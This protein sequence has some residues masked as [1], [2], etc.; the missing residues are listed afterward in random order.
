MKALLPLRPVAHLLLLPLAAGLLLG[1]QFSAQVVTQ[2]PLVVVDHDNSALSRSLIRMIGTNQAF[3][4]NFRSDRDD[5]VDQRLF[6]GEAAA[7]LIVPRNFGADLRE[8]KN[9][10]ILAVYDGSQMS[11]SGAVKSRLNEVL[12]AVRAQF[13]VQY[14]EGKLGQT[15]TSALGTAV[16]MVVVTRL[17]GNPAKS[18]PV[19]ML[20][21]ALFCLVLV[22]Q[23]MLAI[24]LVDGAVTRRRLAFRAALAVVPGTLALLL[25]V[26][27]QSGIFGV[28]FQGTIPAAL[29]LMVLFAASIT[30]LGV[31]LRLALGSR[32]SAIG[33]AGFLSAMMLFAGYTFPLFAMPPLFQGFAWFLPFTHFG[34]PM[35]DLVLLG[36]TLTQVAP[37]LGWL[38]GSVAVFTVGGWALVR[39]GP[40]VRP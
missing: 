7:G 26:V 30:G 27:V 29:S 23:A 25:V 18:T 38:A 16:P 32:R 21:G 22:A 19:F 12:G 10:R 33:V 28:P 24:D 34:L 17:L 37:D 1:Y 6:R 39:W 31:C 20:E 5:E 36:R 40:G 9:P 35:R 13:L 11:L 3:S 14:A 4:V 8:G 15:P 2:V